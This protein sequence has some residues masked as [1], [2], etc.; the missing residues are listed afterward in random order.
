M[1]EDQKRKAMTDPAAIFANPAAV[2]DAPSLS[3]DEKIEILKQWEYDAREIMVADE[4]G[5]QDDAPA[6]LLD[7]VIAAL[8]RLGA[9]SG[10]GNSPPTKQ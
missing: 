6:G 7:D 8:H 10:S 3:R 1:N 4:E 2:V 5:L 9:G